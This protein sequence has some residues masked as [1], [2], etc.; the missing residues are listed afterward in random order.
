MKTILSGILAI[1]GTLS[2]FAQNEEW[3][4]SPKGIAEVRIT[5]SDG[6]KTEDIKNEKHDPDYAGKLEATMRISNST[7]SGYLEEDFYNGKILIEGRGNTTWGVPKK[8]Y[9][10][11]LIQEDGNENPVALLDMPES[12]EWC[13][14][15]FWHDRSLMR[16]PLA[17]YLGQHLDHIQWTPRM[18]YVELWV[19]NDYRGLYCLSEKVQRGDNRIKIKKLTDA[20]EDQVT[21]RISG[22]YILEASS[23]DK[24]D[25]KEKAVQFQTSTDINFSFKY[26]K[27]KNVTPAQREWIRDYIN[28]F[29]SVLWDD[30]KFKDLV[31]GFRKYIDIPSFIDWTILHELSKGC[32]NLFHASIFVHKERN[33]KLNMSAPWDFDLS[34]GNSG[35]YTED[36]NWIRDHR[37]FHR[38]YRDENYAAQYNSRYE[39]LQPL[40]E[41]IPGILQANYHALEE[42]GA[43]EREKNKWPQ[44]LSEYRSQDGFVT[45][46]SHQAHVQYLSEWILSRNT[47][48]YISLGLN[49]QEKGNRMKTIRPIIRLMDPE[50]MQAGSGFDVKVMK[51]DENNNKYTYSWNDGTF[52]NTSSRRISQKGKY[53]VKIKD[54]WGNSSLA[55]DTL[56]FGVEPPTGIAAMVPIIPSITHNNPVKDFLHIYYFSTK[57]CNSPF[58]LFD[59]RGKIVL[60]GSFQI[61]SGNNDIIIPVSGLENGTY[62]LHLYTEERLIARKII[63][64]NPF[65]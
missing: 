28:E 27:A 21:P 38:L 44:I 41:K 10:I 34:F 49:N 13:L 16:I 53:W 31:N 1:W 43:I 57:A 19:N 36:G 9:N 12:E 22:G 47:W 40:V 56:Y 50:S 35:I 5:L 15:A 58:Q 65:E 26:P 45:P 33:E 7:M 17:M 3:L 52:N 48:S 37:W 62:I 51:S 18:R 29:E 54:E 8:P 32:D 6:K 59:I 63:I 20:E 42:S 2:L 24:L 60:S 61:H 23:P 39:A 14:L 11:D 55:S 4:F 46:K 30:N 25:E 64:N